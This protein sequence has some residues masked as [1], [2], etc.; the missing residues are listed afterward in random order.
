MSNLKKASRAAWLMT[1]ASAALMALAAGAQAQQAVDDVETVVV[2]GTRASQQSAIDRKKK[3]KTATDSI[4]ADDVGSF[5]DR[6]LAEALSRIAGVSLARGESGEGEQITLRG[7]T[8]DLTRVEL[9][10]MSAASSGYDLAY[11][12]PSGRSADLRELPADLIKSVDVVKGATPDQTEGGL[13]GTVSIQTRTGLDFKKPFFQLRVA[14]E[15]NSMNEKIA[16]DIGIVASRKFFEGRLGVVF[17]LSARKTYNESHQTSMDNFDQGYYRLVDFD[18]SPEKTFQ[19]NPA[20]VS[21]SAGTLPVGSWDLAS[22]GGQKFTTLTPLEIVTRSANAKTK[23]DCA[24]AFPLYTEAQLNTIAPGTD[25][26]NRRDAQTIRIQEQFTCLSQWNDY[27]PSNLREAV[28]KQ[29]EDRLSWDIRFDY[30]VNDKLT[31]FAK[32]QKTDRKMQDTRTNRARGNIDIDPNSRGGD[33]FASN[34]FALVGNTTFPVNS[35]D[36]ITPTAGNGYYLYNPT[37]LSGY[38]QLDNTAGSVVTN[39]AF[40]IYGQAINIVPGSVKMDSAHHVTSLTLGRA[41]Y[42]LDHIYNDQIWDTSYVQAGG[43][44]KDG[45]LLIEFMGSKQESEYTRYDYRASIKAFY[46]GAEMFATP[47]GTWDIKLPATFNPNDLTQF[48]PFN[49]TTGT[50][51]AQAAAARYTD[52]INLGFGPRLVDTGETQGKADLTYQMPDFPVLKRFKAGIQYRKLDNQVWRGDGYIPKPMVGVPTQ[53][54]RSTV[55]ACENQ[56]TTTVAN[57]CVYGYVPNAYYNYNSSGVATGVRTDWMHG[58]ETLTRA[59]LIQILQNSVLPMEGTFFPGYDDITGMSLWNSID[60]PKLYSQ[61]ASAQNYNTNCLKV[62]KGTDG[63][64]YEMPTNFSSEEITAAYYMFDFEQ[65][66]PFNMIFEGNF[67]VRMVNS[68]VAGSGFT[69]INSVR[70]IT[71][72]GDPLKDWNANEGYGRTQATAITKPISIEREYTDWLPSYNAALWA[73]PDKVVLRYNWAKT[74]A[75]AGVSYLFPAGSC[76]VDQRIEDRIVAGED[77]DQTCGDFGNPDLKPYTATKNNTAIEWYINKDTFVSLA[78][79]RQKIK[80]G[81]PTRKIMVDQ[82][83]FAGSGEVDPVSGKPLSDFT[84]TYNTWINQPGSTQAGWEF[85]SKAALTFLPWRL[86]YTGVDLN[87]STNKASGGGYQDLISGQNLGP[88]GRPEYFGNLSIWY[89]D[90]KTNAKLAYQVRSQVLECIASCDANR[91]PTYAYPNSNPRTYVSLPYNPG[92]AYFNAENAYL[93][94]KITHK[95]K[96]NVEV[97]FE[98]TNVLKEASVR[99]GPTRGLAAVPETPWQVVYGGRKMRF[100][101]I[102]KL[103]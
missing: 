51:T 53:N 86:R 38:R 13:G 28:Q 76:T 66:L 47:S 75:R 3:A 12:N 16:P 62:C 30:R 48:M 60:V 2:V 58:P 88:S 93:D 92:E 98:A 72:T 103:Q 42:N 26:N 31:V 77:L 18:N 61:L 37:Q 21:G 91:L 14:G 22:G 36:F 85:S 97:Y 45:P 6:N 41:E 7:N 94:A 24:A 43:T 100:G 25:N 33:A 102:Y 57:Q 5:P 68:K 39:N 11:G 80:I 40:P 81:S 87:Y 17:N 4:V 64:L 56:T 55:R 79:Y 70:K 1:G 95:V 32:Y 84:F 99:V 90:G 96:Q 74:V 15:R 71:G 34:T 89:D 52:T 78:Y 19:F 73:V 101:V 49:P 27:T 82:P 65:N 69:S 67:G 59:Q 50:P 29:Y 35:S 44:Y 10:G 63:N 9:D 8:A 20:T 23:A 54:L 83:V 46:T